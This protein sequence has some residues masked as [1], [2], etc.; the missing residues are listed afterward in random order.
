MTTSSAGSS[1]PASRTK[2]P[3]RRSTRVSSPRSSAAY[4]SYSGDSS[5]FVVR[6]AP[7][8]RSSS[9]FAPTPPPTSSTESP[10]TPP[11]T[12]KSAIRRA[13]RSSPRR[14]YL[15]T[16]RRAVRSPKTF[17]YPEG[18][19]QPAIARQS[20]LPAVQAITPMLSYE[21]VPGAAEWL[22]P[23]LG[24]SAEPPH[25]EPHGRVSHEELRLGDG[26]V[27]LGN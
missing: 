3:T 26:A 24:L 8:F 2:S 11:L 14:R 4:G 16:S 1:S 7:A 18:V 15:R 13:A 25:P 19:Q 21:D 10:V 17:R 5:T 6:A 9:W 12:R 20:R 22:P 27:M 23:P